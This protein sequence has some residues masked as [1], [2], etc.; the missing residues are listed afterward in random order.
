MSR[1]RLRL[2]VVLGVVVG[3]FMATQAVALAGPPT[4]PA[5]GPDGEFLCPEV[6]NATAAAANGQGWGGPLGSTGNFTFLP[7]NNQSG[8]RVPAKAL[9]TLNPGASP[10]PGG[11]NS[12]W[13][14]HW[15]G[16][17]PNPG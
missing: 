4:G 12:D 10:G 9:N 11:G 2:L 8:A 3:V 6:G 17:N 1:M 13:N 14:P 5:V 15:P 16:T 7:G